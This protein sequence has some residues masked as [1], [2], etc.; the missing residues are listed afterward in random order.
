MSALLVCLGNLLDLGCCHFEPD[1]F[2][3]TLGR[4]L[5]YTTLD[6]FFSIEEHSKSRVCRE[7][8]V[9][10]SRP[11]ASLSVDIIPSSLDNFKGSMKTSKVRR[12]RTRYEEEVRQFTPWVTIGNGIS[13]CA[14]LSKPKLPCPWEENLHHISCGNHQSPSRHF[15]FAAHCM[16]FDSY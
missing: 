15:K 1:L 9:G 10:L 13:T 8:F 7:R 2:S 4:F 14:Y 6:F 12:L 11:S 3:S 5:A 16:A